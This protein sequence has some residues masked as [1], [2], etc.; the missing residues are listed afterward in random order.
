L[1]FPDL[2][3]HLSPE[4]VSAVAEPRRPHMVLSE[5]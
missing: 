2:R 5:R 4:V 1:L 3:D